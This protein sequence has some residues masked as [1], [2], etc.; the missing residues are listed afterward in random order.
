MSRNEVLGYREYWEP[1]PDLD[2]A[3][4]EEAH[5]AIARLPLPHLIHPVEGE[6]FNAPEHAYDCL[7]DY[8]MSCSF[9]IMQR[10]KDKDPNKT[11][12]V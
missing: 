9:C 2:P 1:H 8:A 10:S 6:I 7:Q 4:A 11:Q 5:T 3:L 12:V